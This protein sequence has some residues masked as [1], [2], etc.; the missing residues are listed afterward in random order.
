[1]MLSSL[2]LAAFS[3]LLVTAPSFDHDQFHKNSCLAAAPRYLAPGGRTIFFTDKPC[4]E[5]VG[6]F[7]RWP[8]VYAS[9]L[10]T[11][12]FDGA[13]LL[14]VQ[15]EA[16]SFPDHHTSTGFSFVWGSLDTF[17]KRL[18]NIKM[19]AQDTEQHVFQGQTF[20]PHAEMLAQGPKYGL[21]AIHPTLEAIYDSLLPEWWRGSLIPE[22]EATTIPVPTAAVERV[23]DVL[24][25]A[26]F[27]PVVASLVNNISVPQM[28][29]DIRFL[30]GEDEKSG[31]VSRHSFSSGILVAAQW[32]KERVEE[33]G[34]ICTL[35]PFL[36]G[37]GPN[38]IW[39]V[40]TT[41]R[42]SRDPDSASSKYASTVNTTETVLLSAHYDSR[43]SFGSTRAPGGD[44]D[45]SGTISILGIAR[46]I[47]RRGI[48]F[49]KNVE[50]CLF[51][52]EEQGLLG[53]RAYAREWATSASRVFDSSLLSQASGATLTA[54]WC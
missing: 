22:V 36:A 29:N 33:T 12:S 19:G 24:D 42:S 14:W 16:V 51:A 39:C 31:I 2:S 8:D 40:S 43:G 52:G 45:G 28:R 34:A 9:Q 46:T 15:R 25:K 48:T 7:A 21:I 18:D 50:L 27:D 44:D 47:G 20:V 35:E 30:T 1:M 37:F 41:V 11:P 6:K 54:T 26:K 49:R 32:I 13:Q 23:K 10:K 5:E 3:Y 53:S 4:T 17:F 38:I